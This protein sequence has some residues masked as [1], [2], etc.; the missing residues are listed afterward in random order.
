MRLTLGIVFCAGCAFAQS[1]IEVPAIGAI[2]DSSGSLRSVQGVAG[3]F[4]LGPTLEPAGLSGILAAACSERLC[5]VKTDSKIL[6]PAG[7]ADA[8][9]GPVIF[10]VT[11]DDA[12]VFFPE[13]HTFAWWHDDV[14]DLLD[15]A[16]NGDVLSVLRRDGEIEIAVRKDDQVWI[17]HPDG[18][19]V[20][21][22]ADATGPVRLLPDGVLFAT[23]DEI[24]VRHPDATQARF[25]LAGAGSI[26]AM[27]PHYAAIHMG[28]AMG[29]AGGAIYVVRT[30]NGRESLFLL[31]GTTP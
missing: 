9:P 31:P 25:E 30:E 18:S 12:I 8:P 13:S 19:V 3:S 22:V 2:V 28:G 14:L 17:V 6:S 29:G 11:G 24:V 7:E 26:D 23:A 1:G 10:G 20:D 15:W 21:S 27:G 5:L 16:V 4:W